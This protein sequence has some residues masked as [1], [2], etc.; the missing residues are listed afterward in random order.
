MREKEQVSPITLTTSRGRL[1]MFRS[2][3]Q[4]RS[5]TSLPVRDIPTGHLGEN[6]YCSKTDTTNQFVL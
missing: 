6:I 2:G 5:V 3:G 4:P 1:N